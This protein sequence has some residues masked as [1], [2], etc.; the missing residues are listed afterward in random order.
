LDLKTGRTHQIRVHCAAINHP[1]LGDETYGKSR[2]NT[3]RIK[4]GSEK[5][6]HRQMLHA[7]RIR[8]EH[9]VEKKEMAFEAS[10]PADM[11]EIL[12]FLRGP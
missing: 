4:D 3:I 5:K 8:F 11:K 9:P 7:W 12:D 6:I 10:I 2:Q 1:I